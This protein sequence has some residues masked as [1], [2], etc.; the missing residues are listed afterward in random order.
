MKLEMRGID[1]SFGSVPVLKNM[2]LEILPGEIHALVG[3][4]GAGKSTL[5]KILGGVIQRDVGEIIIDN[6]PV[7]I[8]K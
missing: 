3:E 8:S 5:M 2:Q 1:K 7:E 4:N 6:K